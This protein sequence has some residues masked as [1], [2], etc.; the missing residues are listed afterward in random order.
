MRFAPLPFAQARAKDP[1]F[2][3]T[4][5]F[6]DGEYVHNVHRHIK[7]DKKLTILTILISQQLSLDA[8]LRPT[9]NRLAFSILR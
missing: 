2:Q 4:T 3:E 9:Y 1:C 7:H 8:L 5:R 6:R